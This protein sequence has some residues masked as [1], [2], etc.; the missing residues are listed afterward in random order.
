MG[1]AHGTLQKEKAYKFMNDVW[2][3]MEEQVVCCMI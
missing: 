1:Y 3:Y 2:R